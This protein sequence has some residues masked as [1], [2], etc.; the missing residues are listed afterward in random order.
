M[1]EVCFPPRER[2]LSTTCASLANFLGVGIG[3][4]V[5][6][7][8]NNVEITLQIEAF[9]GVLCFLAYIL[10][11]K[12]DHVQSFHA[13]SYSNFLLCRLKRREIA[14]LLLCGSAIGTSYTLI[15]LL[16]PIL[17]LN[18]YNS[19]ESG[20]AGL[21]LVLGGLTGGLLASLIV[22]TS[23]SFPHPLRLYTVLGSCTAVLQCILVDRYYLYLVCDYFLGVGILGFVPLA[24]RVCVVSAYPLHEL[25]PTYMVFT[26]AQVFALRYTY[27]VLFWQEYT[28]WSGLWVLAA[29]VI[30]SFGPLFWLCRGNSGE[31]RGETDSL[32]SDK[33]L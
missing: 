30:C 31:N 11:A 6:P 8:L 26:F 22:D 21:V 17:S 7:Y 15:G 14:V 29:C 27:P 12:N 20:W 24:M 4:V 18:G 33:P 10:L 23:H 9:G 5:P 16:E 13:V 2:V 25:V 19:L 28:E 3:L 1:A 32:L